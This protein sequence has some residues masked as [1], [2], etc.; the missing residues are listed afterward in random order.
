MSGAI[1]WLN[2]IPASTYFMSLGVIESVAPPTVIID[3]SSIVKSTG[4]DSQ[5]NTLTPVIQQ[6]ERVTLY[7]QLTARRSALQFYS[8]PTVAIYYASGPNLGQP[9]P[10]FAGGALP[11]TFYDI[12]PNITIRAFWILDSL[13]WTPGYYEMCFFLPTEAIVGDTSQGMC[14]FEP[15]GTFQIVALP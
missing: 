7:G 8:P 3:V 11:V 2:G 14:L 15:C 5:F 9:A 4:V 1:G 13:T 6:S 10:P 12:S